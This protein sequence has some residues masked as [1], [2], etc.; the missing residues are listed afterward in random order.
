[1]LFIFKEDIQAEMNPSTESKLKSTEMRN[2]QINPTVSHKES[3]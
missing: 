1:V 2:F 3:R